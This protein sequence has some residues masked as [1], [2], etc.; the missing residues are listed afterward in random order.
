MEKVISIIDLK[1][2][3]A[4]VECVCRHLDPFKTP[5][6]CCDPYRSE[7]SIVMSVSPYLK[8]QYGIPNV[9][10]KRDLPK[11]DGMIYATPRMSY[12]L[13]VSSKIVGVFLEFVDLKDIHVYSVD[14]AFLNIGPYLS[15]YKCG[16]QELVARI[17]RRIKKK[18]GLT[19]TAGVG[20]NPFLAKIALDQEGKKKPPYYAAWSEEDVPRK[21]WKITP[22]S[23]VWRIGTQTE[24]RLKSIGINDMRSLAT[25]SD[26]LLLNAFGILGLELKD[27]ANGRDE[28]DIRNPYVP[29]ETSLSLG[30]TL[31]R[32]YALKEVRLLFK[33]MN[34]DL[35]ER[36][37]LEGKKTSL[38]H[39]WIG[40]EGDFYS[41]QERLPF[42]TA[43]SKLLFEAIE[44]A[45]SYK[46][47]HS[48]IRSIGIAYGKLQEETEG[49]QLSLFESPLEQEKRMSLLRTIDS[50]HHL[51]GKNSVLR[52]SSLL[53]ASTAKR[54]H[55]QIGGHRE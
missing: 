4:S 14:E 39:V 36:M 41:H 49:S 19:A 50:I 25:A 15:L 38:V 53:P 13:D 21:L 22:M 1:S 23:K 7:S 12:Y 33:E 35:S 52:T 32:P 48:P 3:Y 20:P 31:I 16:P 30:Q 40:Y 34:D 5:L 28:S 17:Q 54:R 43:D 46:A 2:F 37:R 10:R 51:Y 29:K 42:A 47:K 6:V 9:C 44:R 18:F 45:I 26:E 27:L 55:E 24:K 8:A 11:I